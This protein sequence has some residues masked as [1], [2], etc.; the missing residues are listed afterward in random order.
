MRSGH[1]SRDWRD[2][3][4]DRYAVIFTPVSLVLVGDGINDAPVDVDSAGDGRRGPGR[5]WRGVRRGRRQRI[6]VDDIGRVADAI[7][8]GRR[9]VRI[10]RQSIIIG[11][12][13]SGAMMVIA[14]LGYIPPTLGA[15]LQE[16]L[17]I[18]VILNAPRAR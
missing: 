2:T 14:A 6:T 16:G 13:L 1:W 11:L 12:G 18:A 3:R 8:I 9:T 17:D 15:L 10:A 7:V 5:A 4:P